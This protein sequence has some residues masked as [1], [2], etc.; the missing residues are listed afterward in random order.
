MHGLTADH[1]R[2]SPIKPHFEQQ[3]SVYAMDRRGRGESGDTPDYNL[4][5]EAEDVVAVVEA[6]GEP[7][8][9]LGHSHGALCSLEAAL[10]TD[11]ISRLILY[12]PPLPGIAPPIPPEIPDRMQA[13]IDNGESEAA[14]ELFL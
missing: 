4:M 13:L 2:W 9:V 11:H 3:F 10:L 12:E 8:F 5:R 7:V 6:I 14:L 1:R